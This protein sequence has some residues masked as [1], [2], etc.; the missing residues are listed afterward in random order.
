MQTAL[1]KPNILPFSKQTAS[2]SSVYYYANKQ[3]E[4]V[5]RSEIYVIKKLNNY[6]LIDGF[7]FIFKLTREDG[8]Y[9]LTS[10]ILSLHSYG[11]TM[12]DAEKMMIERIEEF[13]EDLNEDDRYSGNFV[14]IKNYLNS[15]IYNAQQ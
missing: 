14:K 1:R 11:K 15:V 10:D 2:A 8:Q 3:N 12:K 13:Y 7:E 6:Y 5:S 4:T 9:L